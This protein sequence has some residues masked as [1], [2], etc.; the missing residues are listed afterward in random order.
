ML[1]MYLHRTGLAEGQLAV[2]VG[3]TD[4]VF[5]ATRQGACWFPEKSCPLLWLRFRDSV[6]SLHLQVRF[7]RKPLGQEDTF[8]WIILVLIMGNQTANED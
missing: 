3:H 2:F 7:G 5:I 4:E 6:V 8:C 1:I